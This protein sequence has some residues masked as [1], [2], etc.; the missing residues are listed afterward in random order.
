MPLPMN[1][2][3][4]E[5]VH[6]GRVHTQDGKGPESQAWGPSLVS[7]QLVHMV[8]LEVLVVALEVRRVLHLWVL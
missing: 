5:I 1:L 2:L 8:A 3:G 4:C 6:L 7:M